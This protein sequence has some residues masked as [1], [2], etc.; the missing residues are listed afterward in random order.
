[1]NSSLAVNQTI[2]G[3]YKMSNGADN[4]LI[5][6]VGHNGGPVMITNTEVEK[7]N[8]LVDE[9]FAA[10]Y[11]FRD[12]VRSLNLT[13]KD[14]TEVD[15]VLTTIRRRYI[16]KSYYKITNSANK[17][18]DYT[19]QTWNASPK[20]RTAIK[21]KYEAEK[22]LW[23]SNGNAERD[24]EASVANMA[25]HIYH[26]ASVFASRIEV[27]CGLKAPPKKRE[28]SEKEKGEGELPMSAPLASVPLASDAI[29]IERAN[30]VASY[31][32]NMIALANIAQRIVDKHRRP[33][34]TWGGLENDLVNFISELRLS[35]KEFEVKSA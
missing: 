28:K 31:A 22:A 18:R 27:E 34:E 17:A 7:I 29:M 14:E 25:W 12:F 35:T 33:N 11:K 32:Q 23:V 8:D 20:A 26:N 4:S 5:A 9:V 10:E 2:F 16:Y 24:F 19:D 1:M 30:D 3:E 6:S 13:H 21:S 15:A